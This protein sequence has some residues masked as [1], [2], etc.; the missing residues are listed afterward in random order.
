MSLESGGGNQAVTESKPL[1]RESSAIPSGSTNEP[2]K[3]PSKIEQKKT[4][5]RLEPF[6]PE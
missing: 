5:R 2:A 3:E 1:V 6:V 4:I